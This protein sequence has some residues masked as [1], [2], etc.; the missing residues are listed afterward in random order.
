MMATAWNRIER[1]IMIE[2]RQR[3]VLRMPAA[4]WRAVLELD[5]ECERCGLDSF[6]QAQ[7]ILCAST[8]AEAAAI[9]SHVW[10]YIQHRE[11]IASVDLLLVDLDLRGEQQSHAVSG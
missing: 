11:F 2:D 9:W 8:D 7:I 5:E 10:L 1:G 6:E 3:Y 4:A